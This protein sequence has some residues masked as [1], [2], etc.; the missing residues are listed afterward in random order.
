MGCNGSKAAVAEPVKQQPP[1]EKTRLPTPETEATK[2]GD[3]V[4]QYKLKGLL[5]A[6]LASGELAKAVASFVPTST[7]K[8]DK[9]CEENAA[10]VD[11]KAVGNQ[12][13][14]LPSGLVSD[15]K[16]P[17]MAMSERTASR[18][19]QRQYGQIQWYNDTYGQIQSDT[20]RFPGAKSGM[21]CC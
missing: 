18:Y 19:S 20:M 12:K 4:L 2:V 14:Q 17:E 11:N 5:N 7:A 16:S 13:A 8:P 10:V 9:A 3:V 1:V 21:F 15:M 6:A